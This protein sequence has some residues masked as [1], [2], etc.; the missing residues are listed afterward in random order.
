MTVKVYD[1]LDIAKEH[2]ISLVA[3]EKGLNRDVKW[4]RVMENC[5]VLEYLEEGL[6]L[7]TTGLAIKSKKQ[8]FNLVKNQHEANSS[9]TVIHVGK[10]IKEIP[11][12]IIDYCNEHDYPLMEVPWENSLPMMM[13]DF[14]MLFLEYD[15][16]DKELEE[17][18]KNAI[19][20]SEKTELY[21]PMFKEHGCRENDSYGVAIFEFCEGIELPKDNRKKQ[22]IRKIR[23]ILLS[24]GTKSFFIELERNL[25]I[26]FADY[27]I[28]LINQVVEKLL[29]ALNSLDYD[30]N[31]GIGMNQKGVE[32]IS[33]SY[34][35][36]KWCVKIGRNKNVKNSI[37]HFEDIGV[38]K[39]L[40]RVDYKLLR[41]YYQDTIGVLDEYDK[42]KDT[43]LK[44]L[45]RLYI[46]NNRSEKKVAELLFLH[47]NT[48]N[49]RISKIKK[50]LD[51]DLSDTEEFVRIYLAF[52]IENL[53]S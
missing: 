53:L 32:K 10:N 31:I 17:A 52:C 34:L 6:L 18:F 35:Q 50:L 45:L 12:E 28:E 36:A 8:L 30:F 9:A 4:F 14:S 47:R 19:S 20:Y 43:E 39:I 13:K 44:K 38:Y 41:E 2:G 51:C 23:M 16:I 1:V 5:E 46:N 42:L 21:L 48:V 37:V 29:D 3:G 25:V 27:T 49:Y 40:S 15:R 22:I 11:P 33:D 24:A 26:L 7:F